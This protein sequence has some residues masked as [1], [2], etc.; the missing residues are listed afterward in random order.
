[1]PFV[2][3]SN[4]RLNDGL[5]FYLLKQQQYDEKNIRRRVYD[6]L[7]VLMALDIISKDKKEIQWKGLP[8]TSLSDI[9]ELKVY[10][11]YERLSSCFYPFFYVWI[12]ISL[13]NS[14][15]V[16]NQA[17]RLGLRNRIEKKIAY[18]QELEEQVRIASLNSIGFEREVAYHM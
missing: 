14:F 10:A 7:N 15:N 12:Y 4:V 13:L 18:L 8:R 3:E 11:S 9:E 16:T 17:E 2:L 6:A 1:M 5:P